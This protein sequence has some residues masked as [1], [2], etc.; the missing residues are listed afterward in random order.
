MNESAEHQ[1][2]STQRTAGTPRA[3]GAGRR[4]CPQHVLNRTDE[5]AA[6]SVLGGVLV[7]AGEGT[8]K[9]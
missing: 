3:R 2:H 8:A 6:R 9:T 7:S 4:A 1:F 5:Q